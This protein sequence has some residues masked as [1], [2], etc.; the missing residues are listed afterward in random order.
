MNFVTI[1]FWKWGV[2]VPVSEE[3][4]MVP[5]LTVIPAQGLE[6]QIA[7]HADSR[8]GE[9]VQL[10]MRGEW[11]GTEGPRYKDQ[12]ALMRVVLNIASL[13]PKASAFFFT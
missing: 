7:L 3:R 4:A 1:P 11:G 8:H 13:L 12:I 2:G 5:A 10:G 6:K 9:S